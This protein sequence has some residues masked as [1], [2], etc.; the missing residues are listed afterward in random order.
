MGPAPAAPGPASHQLRSAGSAAMREGRAG[1]AGAS[2]PAVVAIDLG[3]TSMKGALVDAR[4]SVLARLDAPTPAAQ[5]GAAVLAAVL[6]LASDLAVAAP[7]RVVAAA[8]VTPGQV[9]GGVVKFAA[10]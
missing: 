1:G 9:Y 10:N 8:A 3:G 4:G 7:A 2:S 6:R 5:G